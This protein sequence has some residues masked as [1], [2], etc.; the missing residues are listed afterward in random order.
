MAGITYATTTLL[1]AICC[2]LVTAASAYNILVLS[3]ITT[4]SHTNVLKPLVMALADQRGHSVTYWNGLKPPSAFNSTSGNLRVL[5]SSPSDL[6]DINN[7]HGIIRF[8]HRNSPFRLFFDIP[9]RMATY[10]TAVFND[11]I[12]HRLMM[13][14]TD[15]QERYDLLVIE[16]VFNDC[17]LLLAKALDLPFVYFNCMSPT[18]WLL[19]A[20]G[21]PLALDHFPH[22]GFSYTDQMSLWQRT[23]NALSGV[24]IVYFHRWVVMP[25][26]DRVAANILGRNLTPVWDIEDR[27]LSLLMTNSH[28][29]INYQFP[30]LPAV[31]QIGGLYCAPPKPLPEELESFVNAS[32]DDGFIIVSFGSIVKGSQ[33]PDGIRL[34]FLSTFARLNQRVIFKWEDQPGDNVSIP[35]NVKLLPWMPQQDLL[36]HP[37]I[38]LFINHGGL[39][40]KQEAVYHGVPFIALP[41]FADQPINAQKAQDDGYAIKLDWDHLTEEILY[42]AIQRILTDPRYALRMKEVSALSR[43][44]MTSPLERAI[45]WI[46]Y[47]IRHQGAPHLR[48][49]SRQLSLHQR[50]FVD[51]MLVVVSIA[52]LVAYVAI[53]MCRRALLLLALAARK[54]QHDTPR[55]M[56]GSAKKVD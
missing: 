4:P 41:L 21:S 39:N 55:M 9:Q 45:Y 24:M 18:P 44:E 3:P 6:V 36:G 11:P 12:F 38:R 5:H 27:Y 50:G 37:K 29:S 30:M 16:G 26:V 17:A 56:T 31:V 20:V 46:E 10:C 49:A 19:D 13:N 15:N 2:C 1:T 33:V 23:V 40:S 47:V 54:Q 7:D 14:R 22:P 35:S 43:D 25:T 28:F 52:F 8:S 51:V 32:G 53:C 42:D 34:L 48:S